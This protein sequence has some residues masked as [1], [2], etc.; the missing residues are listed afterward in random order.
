M[1]IGYSGKTVLVTG[2]S[3][4]IGRAVAQAFAASDGT[5]AVHYRSNESGGKETLNSLD[6]DGHL[7]VQGDIGTVS[8]T[9]LTLPTSDLV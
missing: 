2:S 5:V 8:Y 1:N 9:H 3:S 7:L 4:G 6:G